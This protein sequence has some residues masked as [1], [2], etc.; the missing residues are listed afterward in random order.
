MKKEIPTRV[1]DKSFFCILYAIKKHIFQQDL[2][3]G[4]IPF[5]KNPGQGKTIGLSVYGALPVCIYLELVKADINRERAS[6]F[7]KMISPYAWQNIL[8]LYKLPMIVPDEKKQPDTQD[9]EDALANEMFKM[10][11]TRP[12]DVFAVFSGN[13]CQILVQEGGDYYECDFEME[14]FGDFLNGPFDGVD[15]G[16]GPVVVT[17]LFSIIRKIETTKVVGI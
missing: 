4:R 17:S 2:N 13:T 11:S 16:G 12:D 14:S 5:L 7:A 15:M 9:E 1:Y 6:E 8:D 10:A 3:A